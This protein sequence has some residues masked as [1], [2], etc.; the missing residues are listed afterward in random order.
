EGALATM[1]PR[2]VFASRTLLVYAGLFGLL[3]VATLIG[4]GA[5]RFP[6]TPGTVAQIVF[7]QTFGFSGNWTE[8]EGRIVGLVRGPRVLLVSI[9]GAGLA[10]AGAA[11][12]GLFRNPLASPQILGVSSGAAFGGA[13]SILLGFSGFAMIAGS[14]SMGVLALVLVGFISSIGGRSET[15]AV[16]LAG[17]VVGTFFSALVSL[18]QLLADPN[19]SL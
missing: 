19:S 14:F 16:I 4:L 1:R 17:V 5:G 13:V 3:I 18:A 7:G 15:T 8:M 6:V 2:D 10:I 12:Q 9:C 11:M